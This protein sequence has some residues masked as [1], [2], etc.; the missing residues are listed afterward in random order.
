MPKQKPKWFRFQCEFDERTTP[1]EVGRMAATAF[2]CAVTERE[3]RGA[4]K[5]DPEAFRGTVQ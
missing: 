2:R 5:A 1:E 3:L 4:V